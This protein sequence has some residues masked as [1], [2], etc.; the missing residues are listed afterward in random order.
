MN[1]ALPLALALLLA[2]AP[3]TAQQPAPT[4]PAMASFADFD[5][6]GD[7]SITEQEFVE[8]RNKRIAERAGQGRPMRGLSQAEEF[9]DIDADGDGRISREEFA[10]HQSRHT[11]PRPGYPR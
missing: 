6:N 11:Q 7:G 10:A 1:I 9:K 8:A 3:A 2:V 4:F 5:T